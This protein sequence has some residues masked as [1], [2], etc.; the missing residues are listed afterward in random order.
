[1]KEGDIVLALF[2]NMENEIKKYRPALVWETTP[3]SARLVYISTQKLVE[4]FQTEIVLSQ[5]EAI[6]IGLSRSSRIDFGKRVNIPIVD[7]KKKLGH[8]SSLPKQTLRKLYY[9]AL[10]AGMKD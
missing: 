7:V 6:M 3:V 1:M 8:V 4:A 10:A 5:E 2:P 9:A